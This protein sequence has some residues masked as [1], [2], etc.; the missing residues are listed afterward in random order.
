MTPSAS[1]VHD[2][3][4]GRIGSRVLALCLVAIGGWLI[5]VGAGL[6]VPRFDCIWPALLVGVGLAMLFEAAFGGARGLLFLGLM[7]ALS[8]GFLL[9]FSIGAWGL[10]WLDMAALW[11]IF[12]VIVA[13][14][15]LVL[16]L[17]G[18]MQE[19][20]LLFPVALIGG[21][22]MAVL[23]FTAGVMTVPY[24][25]QVLQFWPLLAGLA[26]LLLLFGHAD[27]D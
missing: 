5:L 7:A 21:T 4:R 18:G 17:V 3:M 10:G 20:G 13:L 14:A 15:F 24:L 19:A 12:L 2:T 25:L 23:P 6:H 16:Y 22:G 26:L 9:L 1:A 8:G 11:P 27:R